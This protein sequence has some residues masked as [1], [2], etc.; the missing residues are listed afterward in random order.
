M[1]APRVE[2]NYDN[3]KA[4]RTVG[5]AMS[6]WN[7]YQ[8]G[9]YQAGGQLAHNLVVFTRLLRHLG[10]NVSA[11]QVHD[12]AHALPYLDATQRREFKDAA[13]CLLVTRRDDLA[14]FD[15]AF[16]WFWKAREYSADARRAARAVTPGFA[17]PPPPTR[18]QAT[19]VAPLSADPLPQQGKIV[20]IQT[21][22]AQEILRRKDFGSF[23]RAEVED[24]KK[25]MRALPWR[26]GERATRR[27]ERG[28]VEFF[29]AR[30]TMRRNL[31]YGGELLEPLWRKTKYKPRPLVMLC[32]ISGSMENYSRML[33]HF[34]HAWMAAPHTRD[35]Q[36]ECFV[37]GTRLTRITRQLRT[38]SVERA[39]REVAETV[40]DWSGGTRIGDA[41]KTFNFVWAR[42]VLRPGAVA[43]I[44]SDGW[45]RGEPKLLAREMARLRK[46]V[47]RVI[48]LNPLIASDDYAPL[49][50]GLQAA[51]P[52]VDDFL[53]AHN[54]ASFEDLARLLS[55]L[56]LTGASRLPP[57]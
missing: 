39:L 23:T 10:I 49:T 38:R 36:I 55:R 2:R 12:F 7:L 19:A 47:Y 53:P 33:L 5:G 51:L 3:A 54:L 45:D 9:A 22:S 57:R 1:T 52:Y 20:V 27:Q 48:W 46:S 29:D 37:F 16:E 43:L 14:L 34:A 13:R 44:I 31:K 25:L 35:T 30:A 11:T 15:Q 4:V 42:R 21:Y 40:V 26:T 18:F 17:K 28:G 24:A 56:P 41:I 32:D 50:L 6:Q 8:A